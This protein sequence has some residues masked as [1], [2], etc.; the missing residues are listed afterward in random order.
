MP[1]NLNRSVMYDLTSLSI[2]EFSAK[3]TSMPEEN[4]D[5]R[6]VGALV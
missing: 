2:I 1:R 3:E 4:K 5:F 6:A